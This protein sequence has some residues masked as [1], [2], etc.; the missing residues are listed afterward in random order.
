MNGNRML[1]RRAVLSAPALLLGQGAAPPPNVLFVLVDQWRA[2]SL[3]YMGDAQAYTPNLDR[4]AASS[5][6]FTTAVAGSPVCSP[7][8]GCLLSG[9]HAATSG[10]HVNDVPF[11]PHSETLGEAFRK[12]GYRTAYIG[13]WHLYGSPQGTYERRTAPVPPDARFGWEYWKAC[14]C[15]HDYHQSIYYEGDDPERRTWPGYDALAQIEDASQ[16]IRRAANEKTPW[17]VL[18]SLGPPHD[19]YDTAPQ[20]FRDRYLR[21]DL[22]LPPNVPENRREA[23]LRDLRG[24]YAHSA[25][26]DA[27]FGQLL[28]ALE[29]SGQTRDTV[30]VFTSDHGDMLES[31]GLARKQVPWEES[32]RVPLLVRYPRVEVG[33]RRLGMPVG[34]P[35]LFPTLAGLAGVAVP[36]AVQGRDHSAL[37]RGRRRQDPEA[38]AL[39]SMPVSFSVMRR[40]GFAEYRGLR[41]ARYTYVRTRQGPWLLYDNRNDPFQMRNALK[42][43]ARLV[44]ELDRRLEQE[45]KRASDDFLPGAEYVSR[46]NCGHYREVQ[47]PA[48]KTVSAWGDWASTLD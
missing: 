31:Q 17:F 4:F 6:N 45:L 16:Y 14:E 32:I 24:Y 29:Q 48:G 9:Q 39:L 43:E 33:P 19:P 8:R 21:A 38:A 11:A 1:S 35:D 18:L 37:L 42:R 3:G 27:G 2:Q 5:Q 44:R 15:T 20:A 22:K 47:A 10:L 36:G 40:A 41:T 25:A 7:Y 28:R 13:K 12:A 46:A 34:T 30:V 26:L 23:A